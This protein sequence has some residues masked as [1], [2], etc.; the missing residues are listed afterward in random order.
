MLLSIKIHDQ[1]GKI[2]KSYRELKGGGLDLD[3]LIQ[4]LRR[5][6]FTAWVFLIIDR[7][8]FF[9]MIPKR[10]LLIAFKVLC[11][12]YVLSGRGSFVLFL[13]L[14]LQCENRLSIV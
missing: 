13:F 9:Y 10:Y 14:F 2:S 4:S 8:I 1:S 7:R 5:N 11:L 12:V 6:S 3:Q